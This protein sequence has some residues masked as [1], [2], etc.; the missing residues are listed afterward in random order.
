MRSFL[1]IDEYWGC[2]FLTLILPWT[3]YNI[4]LF[5]TTSSERLDPPKTKKCCRKVQW[6]V[7]NEN[8]FSDQ[9]KISKLFRNQILRCKFKNNGKHIQ[10]KFNFFSLEQNLAISFISSFTPTEY[11]QE[12]MQAFRRH[13]QIAYKIK[14]Y[15]RNYENDFQIF[16]SI[17]FYIHFA[18]F[19]IFD[20]IIV[21][22][23]QMRTS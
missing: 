22:P 18:R 7:E 16:C 12:T 3:A 23:P 5:L 6:A 14:T 8:F 10:T 1:A 11:F 9:V 4:T 19:A 13:I 15:L 17:E 20:G 21:R 2:N